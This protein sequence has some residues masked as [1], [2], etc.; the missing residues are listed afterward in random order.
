MKWRT[1]LE[2]E[3][4]AVYWRGS[5]GFVVIYPPL[6]NEQVVCPFTCIHAFMLSPRAKN[7]QTSN[8]FPPHAGLEVLTVVVMKSSG[9]RD[10]MLCSQQKVFWHFGETHHLHLQSWRI[11]QPRNQSEVG[12]NQSDYPMISFTFRLSDYHSIF[13][14]WGHASMQGLLES[15]LVLMCF[16]TSSVQPS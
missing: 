15:T 1:V 11:S 4:I 12:S 6:L 14:L 16:H 9:F 13:W 7:A 8:S 2:N 10:I 3:S 5:E